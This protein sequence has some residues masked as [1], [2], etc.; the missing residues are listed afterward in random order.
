MPPHLD[1]VTITASDFPL[2]LR[3]YDAALTA[4][5][6][7][8][9][10]DLGDEEESDAD[11]EAAGW[12]PIDGEAVLWL[13]VGERGTT[14]AHIALR[15]AS[16]ELVIGFHDAAVAAGAASHDA[17]RRWPIFRRG[18]FNAIVTDPDGNL[19]EAIGPE[20]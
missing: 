19:I 7:V 3:V 20:A 9:T 8:R 17:P 11:V 16:A 6:M 2:S 13:V 12:G 1:H 4:L 14:G 15:A 5:G 18:E 10:L